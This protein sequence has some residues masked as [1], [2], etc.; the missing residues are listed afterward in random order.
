MISFDEAVALVCETARP[1]GRETVPLA[2]AHGR[3][4]ARDV[5]AQVSSP[6]ADSS[7][8]DGYALRERGLATLPAAFR[9]VGE[10]F[11]GRGFTGRV[12]PGTAVRIF[13]GAP[14]PAGADRV[15]IQ[16]NV[17]REG[18]VAIVD[19]AGSGPN[20]RLAGSD[21]AAGEVLVDA[22]ALLGPRALVAAAA[23]DLSEVEVWRRPRLRLLATGDEL[24]EPGT[25]RARPEAIPESVS[26]G[27][28]ALAREWGAE[29]LGRL[30][31]ADDLA[32][33]QPEARAALEDADLVVVTGGASVGER[34]FARAMFGEALEL[35]FSKVAMKPGKPVW[36]GRIGEVLVMGL[37][38]NPTSALV[39]ARLLLAPLL[40]GL[41]GGEPRLALGWQTARLLEPIGPAGDR[42][43]FSRG[44]WDG[45]GVR[46]PLNQ[47]S[48][49]Q[50]TLAKAEILVRRPA[51]E[52]SFGAGDT[53]QVISF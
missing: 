33:M 18:D 3:V 47:D 38:G 28:M 19:E 8:M 40:M 7:A 16:E 10:S 21:F 2:Q 42:E 27:V 12:E 25:V 9:I 46:L 41:T 52:Q 36:L 24:A 14:V 49:A 37:P 31:M 53:V 44:V 39:T 30:R 17:R 15:V 1:L 11:P 6:P 23:A 51:G 4:L 20:I 43:T 45:D 34:D 5:I 13:T 29:P 35:V 26:F 50:K 32:L 22:G 48:G